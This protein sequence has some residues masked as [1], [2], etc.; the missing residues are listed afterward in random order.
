MNPPWFLPNFHLISEMGG[1]FSSKVDVA[2]IEAVE[3]NV[4]SLI[5]R[6]GEEE[7]RI[8][9]CVK[10]RI[11]KALLFYSNVIEKEKR[12]GYI[13]KHKMRKMNELISQAKSKLN[14][15]STIRRTYE[16]TGND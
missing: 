8:D 2:A 13:S 6:L 12:K 5:I 15:I 4:S 1:I 9:D 14:C 7:V 11:S 16:N 10:N 3:F